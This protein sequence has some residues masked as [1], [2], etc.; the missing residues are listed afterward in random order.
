[1]KA[2]AKVMVAVVAGAGLLAA[3]LAAQR[4]P[5]AQGPGGDGARAGFVGPRGAGVEALLRQREA[6]ELTDQQVARLN[7]LRLEHLQAA[8]TDQAERLRIRSDVA[9][10]ERTAAEAREALHEARD[11]A[12]ERRDALRVELQGLLTEA[13]QTRL[14]ELRQ[15]RRAERADGRRGERGDRPRLRDRRPGQGD[16]IPGRPGRQRPGSAR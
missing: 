4:A 11:R 7:T 12:H 14:Q 5:R 13:Q 2:R 16:G 8:Q 6:L 3:P 1:M 10:G 15:Q 9:A